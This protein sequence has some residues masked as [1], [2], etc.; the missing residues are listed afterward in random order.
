ME[1]LHNFLLHAIL[2]TILIIFH[3]FFKQMYFIIIF[4]FRMSSSNFFIYMIA[5]P[6]HL[7]YLQQLW[8][9]KQNDILRA[10]HFIVCVLIYFIL[11]F[12]IL[13][14]NFIVFLFFC[15]ES[16]M[17]MLIY[18]TLVLPIAYFEVDL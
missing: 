10:F 9:T 14:L 11:L 5:L 1:F 17:Y 15:I 3:V 6:N 4:W 16:K 8:D 2:N 7:F 12:L 13:T 18:N